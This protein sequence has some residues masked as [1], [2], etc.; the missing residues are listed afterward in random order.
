[1]SGDFTSSTIGRKIFDTVAFFFAAALLIFPGLI[2]DVLGILLL[3]PP[4]RTLLYKKINKGKIIQNQ[5]I[6]FGN[7]GSDPNMQRDNKC[8]CLFEFTKKSYF[9]RETVR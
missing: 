8:I 3:L 2:T 4:V 1:M 7:D 6:P 5:D 9:I